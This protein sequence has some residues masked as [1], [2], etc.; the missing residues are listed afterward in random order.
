VED[1]R[2][3]ASIFSETGFQHMYIE[4]GKVYVQFHYLKIHVAY[5]KKLR[6]KRKRFL[7]K[8]QF[9]KQKKKST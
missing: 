1:I 8:D 7:A 3:Y 6:Q 5:I 4:R 2:Y 9:P